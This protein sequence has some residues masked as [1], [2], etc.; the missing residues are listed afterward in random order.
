MLN[1]TIKGHIIKGS[2]LS[3]IFSNALCEDWLPEMIDQKSDYNK[4]VVLELYKMSRKDLD[5]INIYKNDID[6]I[7]EQLQ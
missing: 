7:M 4:S 6:S 2:S 3:Q 1:I 5:A